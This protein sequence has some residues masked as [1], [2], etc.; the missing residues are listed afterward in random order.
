SLRQ[1]ITNA[2]HFIPSV[3]PLM[4]KAIDDDQKWVRPQAAEILGQIG[5]P[6]VLAVPRLIT[7][8]KDD[9]EGFRRVTISALMR[10][11]PEDELVI[12]EVLGAITDSHVLVRAAAAEALGNAP[13]NDQVLAVLSQAVSDPRHEVR[14]AAI[15]SLTRFGPKAKAALPA[16]ATAQQDRFLSV[17][18]AANFALQK[19][20]S[21]PP[22]SEQD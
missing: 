21:D 13:A 19:T 3:L 18:G 15:N 8:L 11:A 2:P 16:L 1:L 5:S 4:I 17:R 14:L 20:K 7:A 6:A 9:D 22:T 12:K 10:I